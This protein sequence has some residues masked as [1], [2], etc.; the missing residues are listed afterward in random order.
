[1]MGHTYYYKVGGHALAVTFADE[2]NDD[3]LRQR[4]ESKVAARVV[5]RARKVRPRIEERPVHVE[6]CR[7]HAT[8][9]V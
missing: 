4:L 1:M 6:E 9:H 3:L 7:F 8:H 5:H 2:A